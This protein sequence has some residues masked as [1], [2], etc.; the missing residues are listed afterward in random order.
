VAEVVLGHLAGL[1]LGYAVAPHP[2]GGIVAE[3][4]EQGRVGFFGEPESKIVHESIVAA[5]R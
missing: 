2:A 1:P 4:Y 5:E 3:T